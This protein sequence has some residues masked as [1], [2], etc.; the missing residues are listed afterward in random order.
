M[1]NF[2]VLIRCYKYK[3]LCDEFIYIKC[4]INLFL[5]YVDKEYMIYIN[6]MFRFGLYL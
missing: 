2:W 1:K 4:Y 5:G 3:I 6:F